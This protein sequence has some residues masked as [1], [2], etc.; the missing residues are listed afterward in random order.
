[1]STVG[2][3]QAGSGGGILTPLRLPLFRSVWIANLVGS[4]GWLVQGVGAGWLMTT[5]SGPSA[6]SVQAGCTGELA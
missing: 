5:I 1:M 2:R 4:T 6:S 3:R